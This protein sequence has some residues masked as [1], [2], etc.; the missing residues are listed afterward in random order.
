MSESR[1]V[2]GLLIPGKPRTVGDLTRFVERVEQQREL[3]GTQADSAA[4]DYHAQ[5]ERILRFI[6][7]E[8]RASNGEL[9]HAIP[10]EG[11]DVDV[12]ILGSS[13][14]PSSAA[15]G[16]LGLPYAANYHVSP[17]TVLESVVAYREAFV[18]SDKLHRPYV[19]VSA[20]VVVADSEAAAREL[21]S[22]YGQWVLSIRSGEGAIPF[23]SPAEAAEFEWTEE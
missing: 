16:A 23:P 11:S 9:V 8:F 2:D 5:V 1:L 13:A 7:G 15:A 22:P 4:D 20:D 21:A 10:A 6:D 14:G 17:S 19:A 12:W 18:A 3:L